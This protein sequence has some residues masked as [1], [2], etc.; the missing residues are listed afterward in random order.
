MLIAPH[1]FSALTKD[2]WSDKRHLLFEFRDSRFQFFEFAHFNLV[3]GKLCG[4]RL[5]TRMKCEPI[6]FA[7][8]KSR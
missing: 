3:N 4:F 6:D 2:L 8:I 1:L 7:R 5:M